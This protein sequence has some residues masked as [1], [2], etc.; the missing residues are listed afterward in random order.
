MQWRNVADLLSL[1]IMS[2]ES[3]VSASLE[4][5]ILRLK[6]KVFVTAVFI[7]TF[8]VLIYLNLK[9]VS[10]FFK[11]LCIECIHVHNLIF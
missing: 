1:M 6:E 7:H 9:M 8:Y 3:M 4:F 10:L 2:T 5:V 11:Y